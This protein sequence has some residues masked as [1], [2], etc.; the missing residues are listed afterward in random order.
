M[1]MPKLKRPDIDI[2]DVHIYGGLLLGGVGG[3]QVSPAW[4]LIAIAVV[5]V[6]M[7]VFAPRARSE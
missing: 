1:K 2:Q 5:L 3:W 7:G 4:T 6:L